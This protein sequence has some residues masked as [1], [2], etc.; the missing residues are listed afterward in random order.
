MERRE[1]AVIDFGDGLAHSLGDVLNGCYP[2]FENVVS[3]FPWEGFYCSRPNLVVLKSF[4]YR[5]NLLLD[6]ENY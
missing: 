3:H 2:A 6:G 1:E 5:I 4:F